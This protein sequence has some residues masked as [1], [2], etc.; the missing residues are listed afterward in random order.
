ME[1][2]YIFGAHSRG[3]T[4]AEYMT[5]LYGYEVVAYI[6]DNDESNLS[7][8]AGIPVISLWNEKYEF[9][10]TNTVY[11]ATRGISH[12]NIISNLK[13]KGFSN[14]VPVTPEFDLK[15]RNEY[16]KLYFEDK[17]RDFIK[18]DDLS[19]NNKAND[20]FSLS[21]KESGSDVS[22]YVIRSIFDAKLNDDYFLTELEKELQVGAAL[23][24]ER[25]SDITDD[26]GDNISKYNIQFCEL[27]GIYWV[28]K[29]D[30]KSDIVGIEHYRRH[31]MLPRNWNEIMVSERIDVILPVPLY[32]A[33]SLEE[34]YKKRHISSDWDNMLDVIR[35]D[36]PEIYDSAINF[37][38]EGIYSPCNMVIAKK[39]VF[40]KMCEF[41]FDIVFKCQKLGG[42]KDDKYQ[43]RYPGFL[44]ER[45]MSFYFELN[46][47]KYKVVYADKNFLA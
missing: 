42:Q 11:I 30:N 15:I 19:Q 35:S 10:C 39:E 18:I 27:T 20:S 12:A 29:N 32:V 36:Y 21:D 47:N 31:F 28:W 41:V 6:Y 16:L 46:K 37:F 26:T 44:S 24:T 2:I 33:P 38:H 34:N 14:I 7:S 9:E 40:D 17:N 43:N 13:N 1:K 45:L 8:I 5:K 4:L 25:I 22:N 3:E 23:T